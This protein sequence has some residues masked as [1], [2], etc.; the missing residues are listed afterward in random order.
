M[1]E[2]ETSKF[3]DIVDS[4]MDRFLSLP[5]DCENYDDEVKVICQLV[6]RVTELEKLK[7]NSKE[8]LYKQQHEK[9]MQKMKQSHETQMQVLRN[10]HE[11]IMQKIQT[12]ANEKIQKAEVKTKEEQLKN[13]KLRNYFGFAGGL[14]TF[15]GIMAC[16]V[17]ADGRDKI[18]ILDTSSVHV[19]K[20]PIAKMKFW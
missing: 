10:K 2:K 3:D 7:A 15:I 4:A 16:E 8:N 18:G 11:E 6:D 20:N 5:E 14:L 19:K 13:D 1:E 9:K 12:D 17:M